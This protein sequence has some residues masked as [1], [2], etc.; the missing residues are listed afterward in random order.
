MTGGG[1]QVGASESSVNCKNVLALE[2]FSRTNK[3]VG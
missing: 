2:N 1:F 3:L